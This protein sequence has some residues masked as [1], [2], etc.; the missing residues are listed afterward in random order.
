MAISTFSKIQFGLAGMLA[1][2]G[3]VFFVGFVAPL[4]GRQVSQGS[5]QGFEEREVSMVKGGETLSTHQAILYTIALEGQTE[6]VLYEEPSATPSLARGQH[7]SV[8][9]GKRGLLGKALV[10][11]VK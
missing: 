4:G 5:V 3:A 10:Y 6:P 2:G 7:V 11:E 1:L 9:W 8:T